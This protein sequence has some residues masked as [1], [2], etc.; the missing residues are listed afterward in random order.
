MYARV[1]RISP[2]SWAT[3]TGLPRQ[4]HP[5]KFRVGSR[6]SSHVA[7]SEPTVSL[8]V[9]VSQLEERALKHS[10]MAS[11][12]GLGEKLVGCSWRLRPDACGLDFGSRATRNRHDRLFC[13]VAHIGAHVPTRWTG[14]G[15]AAGEYWYKLQLQ[16]TEA[17]PETLPEM[18]CEIGT[19]CTR[20]VTVDNPLDELVTLT[21]SSSNSRNFCI[22][23]RDLVLQPFGSAQ[24][25]VEYTPSS[26]TEVE[27]GEVA[28]SGAV[29][30]KVVYKC[31]GCVSCV[32][33]VTMI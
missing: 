5:A 20:Q 29:M 26:L 11:G 7:F 25:T 28:V 13:A 18:S 22:K 32:L 30:G 14:V 19:R 12:Q 21:T 2:R 33:S 4:Q 1:V 23:E 17:P 24:L 10:I 16:A 6:R 8:P 9:L 3:T 27:N 31:S 15:A